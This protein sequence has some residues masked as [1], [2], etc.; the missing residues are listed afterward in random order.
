MHDTPTIASAAEADQEAFRAE[1]R[2]W[3]SER[4]EPSTSARDEAEPIRDLIPLLAERGLLGTLIPREYGG[5]DEGL[6]RNVVIAGELAGVSPSLAAMRSVSVVFVALPLLR[7][8][9]HEQKAR[10]LEP[11]AR[12]ESTAALAIT[13]PTAG[14]DAGG[15]QTTATRDG[16]GW[17]ITGTKLYASGSAEAE[18][19]LAYCVTDPDAPVRGRFGA[20]LIPVDAIGRENIA[21]TPT[22]GLRGLSHAT[23]TLDDVVVGADALLGAPEDG[24]GV[25]M[26]GLTPERIDIASRAAGSAARAYREALAYAATREQFGGS[27]RAFQAVT[28]PLAD[29]RCELEAAQLLTLSAAHRFDRGESVDHLAAMAKLFAASRG[30]GICD[31]AMQVAG[32]RGYSKASP[33][34]TMLRDVRALRFGGGTDEVMRHVVQREEFKLLGPVATPGWAS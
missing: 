31:V 8:G 25:M 26:Y 3:L 12:G 30:F 1:I 14:S 34:E 20:F 21:P 5:S 24:Y 33:I 9:T 4:V 6:V 7:Y 29:A 15:I 27:I 2:T 22:L 18:M 19:V 32:A 11:M 17:R 16:D 23:I 13:E 10:W 28:Q